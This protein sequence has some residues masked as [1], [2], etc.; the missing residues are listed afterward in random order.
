MSSDAVSASYAAEAGRRIKDLRLALDEH[1]ARILA[2]IEARSA[3]RKDD[4]EREL[5]I[6]VAGYIARLEEGLHHD[7]GGTSRVA[8]KL[9]RLIAE[10][11]EAH[12]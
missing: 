10:I 8:E 11:S 9:R 12:A 7:R 2:A 4:L 5:L 1:T 3:P 6:E